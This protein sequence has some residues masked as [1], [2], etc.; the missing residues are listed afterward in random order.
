MFIFG[1]LGMVFFE[2]FHGNLKPI[3]F[4]L[5][6]LVLDL[7]VEHPNLK[8]QSPQIFEHQHDTTNGKSIVK[9]CFIYLSLKNTV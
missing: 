6:Y 5:F 1:N 8:V 4:F 7:Q 2:W 3:V 9:L